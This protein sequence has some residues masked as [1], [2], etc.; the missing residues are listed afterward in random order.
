M[1]VKH[2]TSFW[3]VGSVKKRGRHSGD[4]PFS[5]YGIWAGR[6]HQSR[7]AQIRNPHS[8]IRNPPYPSSY[9]FSGR[10]QMLRKRTRSPWSCSI[11]GP[12]SGCGT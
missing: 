7:P 4:G 11:S 3:I 2:G 1:W 6:G 9:P 10:Y 12:A 8:E 5:V